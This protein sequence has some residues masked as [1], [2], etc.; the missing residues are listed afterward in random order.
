[1]L[2]SGWVHR[3]EL[4]VIEF[5]QAAGCRQVAARCPGGGRDGIPGGPPPRAPRIHSAKR[6]LACRPRSGDAHF[7]A[8]LLVTLAERPHENAPRAALA[9]RCA[10]DQGKFWELRHVMIVNANQLQAQNITTY[11][12]DLKLDIDLLNACL[13]SGKY[14][15]DVDQSIAEGRAAGVSGTPSF[16]LGRADGNTVNGVRIVGAQPYATFDSRLKELL[17]Q[18]PPS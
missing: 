7:V 1:M 11:A 12:T 4:I 3:H 5:L 16:V 17:A 9:A 13:A 15:A 10:A 14:R 8:S 2:V 18:V 6:R